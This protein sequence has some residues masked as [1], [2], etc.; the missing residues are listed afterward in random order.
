[1]IEIEKDVVAVKWT[2]K[3]HKEMFEFTSKHGVSFQI[4]YP[5]VVRQEGMDMLLVGEYVVEDILNEK[6]LLPFSDKDIADQYEID[7]KVLPEVPLEVI[8]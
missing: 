4:A 2:G 5:E 7:V 1:M 8:K 3:N 6:P